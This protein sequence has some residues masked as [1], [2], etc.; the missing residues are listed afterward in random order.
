MIEFIGYGNK[1]ADSLTD[2]YCNS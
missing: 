1:A 2:L